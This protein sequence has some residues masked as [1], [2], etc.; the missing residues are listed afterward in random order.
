MKPA[1]KAVKARTAGRYLVKVDI[2]FELAEAILASTDY[3]LLHC[4]PKKI[5][6]S[7]GSKGQTL[8]CHCGHGR[9]SDDGFTSS[10]INVLD[11]MRLD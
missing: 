2:A 5:R 6:A 3:D 9:V 4:K 1:A 8:L 7:P 10:A 11:L